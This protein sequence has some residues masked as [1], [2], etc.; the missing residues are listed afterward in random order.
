M[1]VTYGGQ[2]ELKT[3]GIFT[4]QHYAYESVLIS[5][6]RMGNHRGFG[7]YG[8]LCDHYEWWRNRK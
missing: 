4:E 7:F 2:Y 8:Y 1:K 5:D 3:F 6:E